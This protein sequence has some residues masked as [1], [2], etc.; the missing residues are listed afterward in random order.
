MDFGSSRVVSLGG[1]RSRAG[2]SKQEL[3][4]ESRRLRAERERTHGRTRAAA[5]INRVARGAHSRWRLARRLREELL[6]NAAAQPSLGAGLSL[7]RRLGWLRRVH[8]RMPDAEVT[9]VVATAILADH[10]RLCSARC[11]C[12]AAPDGLGSAAWGR[13]V[14]AVCPALFGAASAGGDASARLLELLLVPQEK[15]M[16]DCCS[17]TVS[18]E[19]RHLL[20]LEAPRCIAALAAAIRDPHWEHEQSGI[21]SAAL[22][23]L[24]SVT[25]QALKVD[26]KGTNDEVHVPRSASANGSSTSGAS[27]DVMPLFA[28]HFRPAELLFRPPPITSQARIALRAL[29]VDWTPAA[30]SAFVLAV[31][32]ALGPWQK[33]GILANGAERHSAASLLIETL[34]TCASGKSCDW[35]TSGWCEASPRLLPP[36]ELSTLPRVLASRLAASLASGGCQSDFAA[37]PPMHVSEADAMLALVRNGWRPDVAAE[38]LRS[39]LSSPPEP[40]DT[41][42]SDA[43]QAAHNA[44]TTPVCGICL[45]SPT[46]PCELASLRCGHQFCTDC[47]G[48]YL[49]TSLT[50][51]AGCVQARCPQP[52]CDSRVVGSLW[53][54]CMGQ[55][56]PGN[57]WERL[58]NRSFVAANRLL[59]YCPSATCQIAVALVSQGAANVR[60][61]CGTSFCALCGEEAHFPASCEEKRE[62]ERLLTQSPDAQFLALHTRPCPSCG[63][64]TQREK[65]C[66]HITCTNCAAEWCWACGQ[67]GSRGQVHHVSQCSRTPD[68][69][70]AFE[71]EQR[72]IIDGSFASAFD[73][74]VYCAEIGEVISVASNPTGGTPAPKSKC[75]ENLCSTLDEVM[76]LLRWAHIYTYFNA[77]RAAAAPVPPS[78][79][80]V[81]SHLERHADWLLTRSGLMGGE[82]D[83][84]ALSSTAGVAREQWVIS[85]MLHLR[86]CLTQDG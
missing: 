75:R 4:E 30:Q 69:S 17:L 42:L 76:C 72:R 66:M 37:G 52:Q 21:S 58:R 35:R 85:C 10:E 50:S 12:G 82:P 9:E 74:A 25:R 13:L 34:S 32:E 62:W 23:S 14:R 56:S 47:W 19:A 27:M 53:E 31:A 22:M 36:A 70:W 29:F 33:E 8:P 54:R 77:H 43:Q 1:A 67:T 51:G 81:L 57:A 44:D 71:R 15:S 26:R 16:P 11:A 39:D 28:R 59:C 73:A 5:L 6:L 61:K 79:R 83:L 20:A 78:V 65:G 38:E 55:G 86:S 63:A 48:M 45:E 3:L 68:P 24:V 2:K 7:A 60:C 84:E 64:R 18:F 49:K 40:A 80:L 46:P 41:R